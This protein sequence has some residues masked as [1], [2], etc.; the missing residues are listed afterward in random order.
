[1]AQGGLLALAAR[2]ERRRSLL[3]AAKLA[4]VALA[5]IWGFAVTFVFVRLLPFD[6]FRVFLLLVAFANF[7]ISAEL[8]FSTVIYSRLRRA[9]LAAD[10]AFRSEELGVLLLFM[11]GIVGLGA[12]V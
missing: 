2:L 8:G 1:M 4:N 12:I 11:L 10:G 7:T 3:G 5:M 6:D 9:K